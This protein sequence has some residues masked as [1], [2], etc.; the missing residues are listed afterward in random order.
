M[1]LLNRYPHEKSYFSDCILY[2]KLV[3]GNKSTTIEIWH[4]SLLERR[5]RSLKAVEE[6]KLVVTPIFSYYGW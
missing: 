4:T 3:T 5:V 1:M 2:M 6:K